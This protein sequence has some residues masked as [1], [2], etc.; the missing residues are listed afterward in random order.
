MDTLYVAQGL[1]CRSGNTNEL[2]VRDLS[3]NQYNTV[4]TGDIDVC[5]VEV[6]VGIRDPGLGEGD[7]L[8]IVERV[9]D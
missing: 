7:V 5:A 4:V 3:C 8:G 9:A 6:R 1:H 2:S